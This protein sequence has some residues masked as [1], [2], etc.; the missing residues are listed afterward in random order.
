M[1]IAQCAVRVSCNV[2]IH[3]NA[4]VGLF[5][6]RTLDTDHPINFRVRSLFSGNF[7]HIHT[8]EWHTERI[9]YCTQTHQIA[10][11]DK[12]LA[13]FFCLQCVLIAANDDSIS[14]LLKM[15]IYTA[16]FHMKQIKNG[17]RLELKKFWML[18]MEIADGHKK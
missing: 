1:T 5:L 13:A 14:L 8:A 9:W 18:C 4:N 15:T 12:C 6:R 3:S 11:Q 17:L 10:N 2:N 16:S 7:P